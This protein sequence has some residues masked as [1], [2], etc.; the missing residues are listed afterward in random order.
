MDVDYTTE[1]GC[2]T[3]VMLLGVE[4][5]T[6]PSLQL[7]KL[8]ELVAEQIACRAGPLTTRDIRFLRTYLGLNTMVHRKPNLHVSVLPPEDEAY[9]R[10]EVC[11][12]IEGVQTSEEE[13][14]ALIAQHVDP[15][16]KINIDVS[17]STCYR[18]LLAA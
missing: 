16:F 3:P 2:D 14:L 6:E 8:H 13:L 1:L 10:Y 5:G 15:N 4:D 9:L 17:D 11:K 18:V 7:N 12:E